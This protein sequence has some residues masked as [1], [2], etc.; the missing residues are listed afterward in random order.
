MGTPALAGVLSSVIVGCFILSHI[1]T[2]QDSS[3][4]TPWRLSL[5][6]SGGNIKDDQRLAGILGQINTEALWLAI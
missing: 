6:S 3:L 5:D 2:Q 1:R 4:H